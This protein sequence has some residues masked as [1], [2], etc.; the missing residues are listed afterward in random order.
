MNWKTEFVDDIHI[1]NHV[2]WS[3]LKIQIKAERK[4][5]NN[6]DAS[7]P[8]AMCFISYSSEQNYKMKYV[9][10]AKFMK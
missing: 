3:K 8:L 1:S 2:V 10:P 9:S 5:E 4:K 6:Q 7:C